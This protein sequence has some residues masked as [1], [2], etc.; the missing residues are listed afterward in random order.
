MSKCV[1]VCVCVCVCACV[2][3]CVRACLC[4]SVGVLTETDID[5]LLSNIPKPAKVSKFILVRKLDH[6]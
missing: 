3:A 5:I 4:V 2:R 1:C 6:E